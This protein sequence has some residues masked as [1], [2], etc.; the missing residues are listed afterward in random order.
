MVERAWGHN[1]GDEY[2]LQT[3]CE[4]EVYLHSAWLVSFL[5]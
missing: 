4:M 5:G 1:V 3:L 2:T